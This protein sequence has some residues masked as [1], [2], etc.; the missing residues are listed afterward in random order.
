MACGKNSEGVIT[1]GEIIA[2]VDFVVFNAGTD[3]IFH[4]GIQGT[5]IDITV[6]SL[7][8]ANW[9]LI[10]I[11]VMIFVLEN[12][13]TLCKFL[14]CLTQWWAMLCEVLE[15]VYNDK[16]MVDIELSTLSR[17]LDI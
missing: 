17:V 9:R 7:M 12:T 1:E 6:T 16:E 2:L 8:S 11:M 5:I 13:R 15:H 14:R 3:H 4:W 10:V